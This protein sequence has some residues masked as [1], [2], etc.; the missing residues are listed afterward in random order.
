M[1]NTKIFY[2]HLN[3]I[4]EYM[5]REEDRHFRESLNDEDTKNKNIFVEKLKKHILYSIMV[6]IN[7]GDLTKVEQ[8]V[9][10]YWEE[11]G[12]P[13]EA[14]DTQEL[15]FI[16]AFKNDDFETVKKLFEEKKNKQK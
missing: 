12:D 15:E 13:E 5:Y 8:W 11:E 10:D 4:V 1:S 7:K 6:T 3:K 16:E 2:E 14:D 9:E